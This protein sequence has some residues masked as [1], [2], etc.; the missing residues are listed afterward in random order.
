[1]APFYPHF[2]SYSYAYLRP[3]CIYLDM[4][5]LV[6]LLLIDFYAFT[7]LYHFAGH[8]ST[9]LVFMWL[10]PMALIPDIHARRAARA[11][12][13]PGMDIGSL[14]GPSGLRA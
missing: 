13:T 9:T 5:A 12:A 10:H 4:I 1:M 7:I 8:R 2:R 3:S 6:T 11:D 14:A